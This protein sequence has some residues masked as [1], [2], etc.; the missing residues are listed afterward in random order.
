MKRCIALACVLAAA[1][2]GDA[3]RDPQ[4]EAL[5]GEFPGTTPSQFHRP[6][7]PCVLCH[8]SYEGA[9]PELSIGGTLFYFPPDGAGFPV[10]TPGFV[11]SIVDSKGKSFN[12]EV[13]CFGNFFIEKSVFEPAY[14]ILTEVLQRDEETGELR[15]NQ[16]MNSRIGRDGSCAAC[17]VDPKSWL[18]P[19][20]VFVAG[21]PEDFDPPAPD[22][23]C[24]E[25]FQ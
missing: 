8:D 11:V 12:A 10:T 19:G 4:I 24:A 1:G 13:N 16:Q 7:Q 17:H 20:P 15:T 18:S 3:F 21:A 5:G 2:C 25:A 22:G 14:P 9:E 6:G 23:A